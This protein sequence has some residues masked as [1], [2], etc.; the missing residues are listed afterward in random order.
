MHCRFYKEGTAVP[1]ITVTAAKSD[2]TAGKIQDKRVVATEPQCN[3]I[4]ILSIHPLVWVADSLRI[5]R[6][7]PSSSGGS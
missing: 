3:L 7:Q 1:L 4:L 2:H 6:F 5:G